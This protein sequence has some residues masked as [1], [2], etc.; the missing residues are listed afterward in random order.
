MK[1]NKELV[2]YLCR[3][4]VLKS[5]NI[6]NSFYN[7]DRQDFVEKKTKSFAYIDKPL[8][9]WYWQTISQPSTV[10]FM[11]ELLNPKNWENILDIWT[12]SWWTTTLLLDIVW[13]KWHVLWLERIDKLVKFGNENI[14]KYK[15]SNKKNIQ[16]AGK[17]LWI[18]WKQFDKI[19]VSAAT[20]TIPNELVEQLV[21]WWIMIIPIKESI[22]KIKK[23]STNNYSQEEYPNFIFVPLIRNI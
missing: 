10:W 2:D 18:P 1:S 3:N 7:I 9:I 17:K 6:I 4:S 14:N 13:A 11:L 16:K 23:I 5:K 12:G 8:S 19:L 21:I 20:E 22:I 15:L